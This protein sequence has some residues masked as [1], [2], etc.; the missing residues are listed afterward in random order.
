[1]IEVVGVIADRAL[2]STHDPTTVED[3]AMSTIE[4]A[5]AWRKCSNCKE[6]IGFGQRYYR[7]NVSTC[8]RLRAPLQFCCVECWEA[9]V[10]TMRHRDAWAEEERAPTREQA[11]HDEVAVRAE[12]RP[13]QP[14]AP[15][16]GSA[17]SAPAEPPRRRYVQASGGAT[18]TA[19]PSGTAAPN[20]ILIIASRL[21]AY[22][23]TRCG[24]NTSDRVLEPLS[25]VV[26]DLC[27]EAIERARRDGR[28]T[29]L[30][31]DV[32]KR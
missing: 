17:S 5:S 7:C 19:G 31:R 10:P 26:R 8:N 6:P 13:Q 1:M 15:P 28:S 14:A 11:R 2:A 4:T 22:I 9:H 29:I 3:P 12:A 16:A 32:P 25:D 18:T 30:E 23:R 24:M 20:E 27:D 21:K